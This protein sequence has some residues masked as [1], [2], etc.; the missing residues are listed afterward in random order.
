MLVP[1]DDDLYKELDKVAEKLGLTTEYVAELAI[2][3]LIESSK[4]K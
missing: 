1:V 3:H 4:N 2:E